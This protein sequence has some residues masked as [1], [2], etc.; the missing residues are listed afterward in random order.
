MKANFGFGEILGHLVVW[1][2]IIV[3][4]LGLGM[5]FFPYSF[6]K[7]VL[8]RTEVHTSEGVY[9]L[10]CD[11]DVFSQMGH[12][13]LWFVIAILTLGLGYFFY[14]YGVWRVVASNTKAIRI[15]DSRT[16]GGQLSEPSLGNLP[17][18]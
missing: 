8:N 4:T 11:L 16:S 5:F 12:I 9:T 1:L 2:L 3:V 7:F 6:A 10:K 15:P 13:L 18:T 14:L 17:S